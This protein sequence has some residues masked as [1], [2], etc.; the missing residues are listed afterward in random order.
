[1]DKSLPANSGDMGSIPGPGRFHMLQSNKAHALQILSLRSMPCEPQLP[2]PSAELLKPYYCPKP[3]LCSKRSHRNAKPVHRNEEQPPL[4]TTRESP[5][6]ATMIQCH[7]KE[8]N[9]KKLHA[10][11]L[12]GDNYSFTLKCILHNSCFVSLAHEEVE[13]I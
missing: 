12:L 6:A 9:E 5:H 11:K 10:E 7:H 2:S 8:R 13:R 1:M 4:T 3:V